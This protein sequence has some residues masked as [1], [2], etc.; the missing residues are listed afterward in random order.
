MFWLATAVVLALPTMQ[1]MQ[2]S[3]MGASS[4]R[5]RCATGRDTATHTTSLPRKKLHRFDNVQNVTNNTYNIQKP[6]RNCAAASAG[7]VAEQC[8]P[9]GSLHLLAL[10]DVPDEWTER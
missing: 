9:P 7:R 8:T 4:R 3:V 6:Q 5:Y 1:L 10:S 2:P